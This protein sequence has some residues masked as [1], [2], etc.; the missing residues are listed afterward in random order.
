MSKT[1]EDLFK[2]VLSGSYQDTKADLHYLVVNNVIE[3]FFAPILVDSDTQWY[4]YSVVEPVHWGGQD[5]MP[6][7]IIKSKH[8]H[9]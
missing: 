3:A 9:I 4:N 7:D 1:E 2:S 8:D 5:R 6:G